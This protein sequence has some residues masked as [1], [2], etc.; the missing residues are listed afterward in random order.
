MQPMASLPAKAVWSCG[1]S[2]PAG[3]S[4]LLHFPFAFS[5]SIFSGRGDVPTLPSSPA[6]AHL[7]GATRAVAAGPA[8]LVKHSELLASSSHAISE[9]EQIPPPTH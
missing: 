1:S 8:L 2:P 5:Q 4:P 3:L 7:G 6:V 9:I